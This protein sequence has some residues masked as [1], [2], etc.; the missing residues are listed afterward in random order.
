MEHTED[1]CL[2]RGKDGKTT[3][4]S[5]N[6]L[7]VLVNDGKATLEQLN[8]L[9]N[10]K[11]DIFFGTRIPKRRLPVETVDVEVTNEGE[12]VCVDSG[13]NPIICSKILHHFI[14]RNIFLFPM[15]TILPILDELESLE[16]LVK[17]ARKKCLKV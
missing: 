12:I 8:M 3:P 11:H 13:K 4:T 9:C 17:L 7:E 15:E 14:K 2:K 10:I 1:R 16:S 6:Y 5:N